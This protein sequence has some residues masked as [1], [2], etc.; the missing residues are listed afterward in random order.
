MISI[1]LNCAT[2][3]E[4]H[5]TLRKLLPE[6]IENIEVRQVSPVDQ[7]MER[8]REQAAGPQKTRTEVVDR[9]KEEPK[10]EPV[11]AA[12]QPKDEKPKRT[13]R[14]KAEI[15]AEAQAKRPAPEQ[16]FETKQ[17]DTKAAEPVAVNAQ[18]ANIAPGVVNKEVVHQALQQVNINVGLHKAREILQK[19][20][21]NRISEI[22]ED[23]FKAFVDV[24]NEA[25]M[26]S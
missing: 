24:C 11:P 7:L 12:A 22:K 18:P 25:V 3:A 8:A 13:R 14:T 19:F 20:N 1:T 23:Q 15:E 16:S 5:E 10:S 21:V 4:L 2:V 17:H 26:S 9:M 6:Q